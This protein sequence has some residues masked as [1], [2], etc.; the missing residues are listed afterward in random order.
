MNFVRPLTTFPTCILLVGHVTSPAVRYCL[1][2]PGRWV[3]ILVA[4]CDILWWTNLHLMMF[5]SEF[6]L[7]TPPSQHSTI[8]P[9]Q[10]HIGAGGSRVIGIGLLPYGKGPTMLFISIH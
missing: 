7:V 4:S 1:L 9:Y 10:G 6:L 3:Q 5:F 2:I 8:T